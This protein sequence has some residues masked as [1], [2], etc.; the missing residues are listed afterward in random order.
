MKTRKALAFAVAACLIAASALLWGGCGGAGTRAPSTMEV[1]QLASGPISG[2]LEDGIWTYKG[3][4][5]AAPPTGDMRWREPQPVEPWEEVRACTEYGPACPQSGGDWMGMLSVGVTDEDCLYLNV[6]TPAE[7]PGEDLP[8]MV[9]IHGGSFKSG[10]GSLPI[11]DG[12]NLARKGVVLVTINYRLGALG[13]MAHPLL[14]KESTHGVSGNYGLLDQIAALKW[15]RENIEAFG[16]DP[17]NVTIFGESAGGM[18]VLDLMA[19]P[20]A[21]GLFHRAVVESGPLLDLGLPINRGNTLEAAEDQGEDVSEDLGCDDAEDELAA[22]REVPAEELVKFSSSENELFSPVNFGPNIDGYVL[23]QSPSEAFAAGEQAAV[24]LLTGTNANEG[25]IF[26]PPI[27]RQQLE[28]LAGYLY[29]DA[30]AEVLSLFPVEGEDI[31]PAMDKFITRMG[32]ASSSRFTAESMAEAGAPAYLYEFVRTS[33]DP[34]ASS[35]GSFHGLEI[36]YVFGNFDQLQVEGIT[37]ADRDLSMAMMSYWTNFAATGDPNG[38]G[39]PAWPAYASDGGHY[40]E[41][42]ETITTRTGLYDQVYELV[43]RISGL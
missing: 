36:V 38:E 24:P 12:G 43:V 35:L 39:V 22:L 21:E 13:F 42:G 28:L 6:W 2:T 15:V 17:A 10:A 11:Y 14:S 31:K 32:F 37:Q 33:P 40:Q 27:T 18:S 30:A 34:R 16:G 5:F 3:I 41:L 20:L 25:T 26:I 4:P 19:S 1:P 9:W 7:D 23:P 29:G 8:V